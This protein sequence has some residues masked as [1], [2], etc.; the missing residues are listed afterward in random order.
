MT[1]IAARSTHT[2]RYALLIFRGGRFL[3][4]IGVIKRRITIGRDRWCDV[5]LDDA[6]IPARWGEI[7]GTGD[8][9][10]EGAGE[11]PRRQDG[12]GEDTGSFALEGLRAPAPPPGAGGGLGMASGTMHGAGPSA[13]KSAARART[14]PMGMPAGAL[15][16]I[17]MPA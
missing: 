13:P 10:S 7:V 4:S 1:G 9:E 16:P 8:E 14:A 5:V 6:A 3:R 17:V 11:P 12:V 2:G 15:A